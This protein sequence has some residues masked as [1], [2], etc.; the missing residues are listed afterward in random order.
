MNAYEIKQAERQGR[1]LELAEK[2]E[3]QAETVSSHARQRQNMIPLGQPILVGHH[4]EGRDRRFRAK[5]EQGWRKAHELYE[6]AK[7]YRGKAA[8]VG[9][10]GIS[11]DDP[12]A[13]DKIQ[14]RIAKLEKKQAFMVAANKLVRKKDIPGLMALGMTEAVAQKLLEPDFCGR[15]GFPDYALSNNS[16]NI[17]RLKQ[18]ANS[19]K[20]EED[21]P[22]V[23]EE[24][25]G[26][27]Y[28]EDHGENR[29]MFEFPGKPDESTRTLLKRNGFKWSPTRGAWVRQLNNA[30]RY[31]GGEVKE[32]LAK[33]KGVIA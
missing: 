22:E 6:K 8:G 13:P 26:F 32:Q 4:S 24:H 15:L 17:R 27:T 3:K 19:L 30:G 29:V 11:S 25:K 2:F 28:R 14:E 18:R 9:H 31:A 1:F 12:D 5:I 21:K 7:Y 16:A 10:A 23:E 20:R 33:M